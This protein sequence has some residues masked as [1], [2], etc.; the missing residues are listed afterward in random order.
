MT[1]VPQMYSGLQNTSSVA[2]QQPILTPQRGNRSLHLG[3]VYHNYN[4]K[5]LDL[6]VYNKEGKMQ[7]LCSCI[8]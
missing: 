7:V 6:L 3:P 1:T 8:T 2:L 4:S 5:W